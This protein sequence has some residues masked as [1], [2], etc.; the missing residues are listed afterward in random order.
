MH[1]QTGMHT[2]IYIAYIYI[3]IHTYTYSYVTYIQYIRAHTHTYLPTC[4]PTYL[5]AYVRTCI[6]TYIHTYIH[7]SYGICMCTQVWPTSIHRKRDVPVLARRDAAAS[8]HVC[9][10]NYPAYR[11]N[12]P[13]GSIYTIY[14]IRPPKNHPC[15]G[16]G[17]LIP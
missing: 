7:T 14:G 2:N 1:P 4:L 15:F 13:R 17:D 12:N 11:C 8:S 10:H 5:P 16:F 6:H 9:L 3:H